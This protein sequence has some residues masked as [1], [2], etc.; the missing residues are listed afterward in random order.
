MLKNLFLSKKGQ[1]KT[2]IDEFAYILL[3]GVILIAI[4]MFASSTIQKE[5]PLIVMPSDVFIP[6]QRGTFTEFNFTLEG[7]ATKV[8]IEATGDAKDWI[9]F[10]KNYFNVIKQKTI[11]AKVVVP[12]SISAGQYHSIIVVS[13]SGGNR[14]LDVMIDVRDEPIDIAKT[15]SLGDFSVSYAI[16]TDVLTSK[17]D[18]EVYQGVF[19]SKDVNLVHESMDDGKYAIVNSGFISLLIEDAN[20]AGEL[21]IELNGEEIFKSKQGIGELIIPLNK[22]QIKKANT[23]KIKAGGP[24][25]AFWATNSF[26]IKTAKFAVNYKSTPS[27]D[28]EFNLETKEVIKFRFGKVSFRVDEFTKSNDMIIKVNN[29]RIFRGVPLNPFEIDFENVPLNVGVNTITF[30]LDREA[31]YDL[32]NVILTIV[33]AQ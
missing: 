11:K 1:T 25:F 18:V 8:I 23:V 9:N 26:K 24:G 19:S 27:V 21:I 22:D 29:V 20:E 15:I 32:S 3:A 2:K 16:G 30:F 4:V 5:S 10:D 14:T 31:K 33:Y 6:V 13:S 7:N 12:S 17:R 28:K